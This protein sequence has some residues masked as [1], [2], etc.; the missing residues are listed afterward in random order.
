MDDDNISDFLGSI[1][2]QLRESQIIW[3]KTG[4]KAAPNPGTS[5]KLAIEG[6]PTDYVDAIRDLYENIQGESASIYVGG[7]AG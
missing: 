1:R 6:M 2:R 3:M 5:A 4:H 7:T